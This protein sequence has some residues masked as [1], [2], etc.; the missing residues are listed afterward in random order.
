MHRSISIE[1]RY[2]TTRNQKLHLTVSGQTVRVYSRRGHQKARQDLA[3]I[4]EIFSLLAVPVPVEEFLPDDTS[5]M[6]LLA[7]LQ[8]PV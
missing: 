7:P 6:I 2:S 5:K 3:M 4:R 8:G 1:K